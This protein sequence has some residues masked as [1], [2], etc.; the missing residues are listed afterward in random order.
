VPLPDCFKTLGLLGA[1]VSVST[2]QTGEPFPVTPQLQSSGRVP[3]FTASNFSSTAEA[4]VAVS[5]ITI[6]RASDEN[7]F[8]FPSMRNLLAKRALR[9]A[10]TVTV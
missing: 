7:L 1:D 6:E 3:G 10:W 8:R 4:L 2:F 9:R 5:I